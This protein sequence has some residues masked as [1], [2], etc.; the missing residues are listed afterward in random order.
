MPNGM[1]RNDGAGGGGDDGGKTPKSGYN[2]WIDAPIGAGGGGDD[3]GKPPKR[4]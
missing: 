3:G 1:Q 4:I 2:E